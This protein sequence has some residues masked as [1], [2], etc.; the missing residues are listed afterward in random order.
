MQPALARAVSAELRSTVSASRRLAGGDIHEAFEARLADGR[1]IFIKTNANVSSRM[2]PCEARGLQWLRE[3]GALRV[4]DVL[5]VSNA[6]AREQFLVLELVRSAPRMRD[7]DERLGRG[8][9]ALHRSGAPSFGFHEDNFIGTLPQV[10]TPHRTWAEFYAECRLA[11]T[12]TRAVDAGRAPRAWIDRF[13]QLESRL[14][15]LL[16]PEEAPSRLHGDL[17]GGNVMSDEQGHPVLVDP[18]VY[19]G[20]REVD[21]AMLRL[22]G[23]PGPALLGAYHEVWPLAPGCEDRVPLHQLYPLLVHVNLF[24]G[25]YVNAADAILRRYTS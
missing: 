7:F 12:L 18:A 24:G 5:A 10:N 3:S 6:D 16:G 4:P 19:G 20:H 1:H 17:W 21:L 8:L 22:F 23:S 11:P 25:G 13:A 9:A 15:A 2:F 14:H